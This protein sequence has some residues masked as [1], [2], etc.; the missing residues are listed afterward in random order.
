MIHSANRHERNYFCVNIPFCHL[1]WDLIKA[2]LSNTM[3]GK[4][5]RAN[6]KGKNILTKKCIQHT[7]EKRITSESICVYLTQE[8]TFH[9]EQISDTAMKTFMCTKYRTV[10]FVQRG[11]KSIWNGSSEQINR[12]K[13]KNGEK[14]H[15]GSMHNNIK[16][17]RMS[18]SN[19][20]SSNKEK[21]VAITIS[22]QQCNN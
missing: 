13:R 6:T 4:C 17:W 19:S 14:I 11:V 7:N 21:C 20:S 10:R 18:E 12:K 2:T 3:N 22:T 16:G 9:I 15:N 8:K 1:Y 5:K